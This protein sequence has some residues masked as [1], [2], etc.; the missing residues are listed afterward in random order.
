VFIP[1]SLSPPL[2]SPLGRCF[3]SVSSLLHAYRTFN[4]AMTMW[5][6]VS[7]PIRFSFLLPSRVSNY[8]KGRSHATLYCLLHQSFL[9]SLHHL[10][11]QQ[12]KSIWVTSS[13]QSLALCPPSF[14]YVLLHYISRLCWYQRL[15]PTSSLPSSGVSELS[16]LP[17]STVSL[18]LCMMDSA[19]PSPHLWQVW[20]WW[21]SRYEGLVG[22]GVTMV[23]YLHA[24]LPLML[25]I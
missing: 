15:S 14:R 25:M 17:S 18:L 13:Q 12:I 9:L 22:G 4:N 11:H 10:S 23:S 2:P 24:C 6:Q 8:L 19:N 20:W 3:F 5:R 21:T 16:Y 7:I 1:P